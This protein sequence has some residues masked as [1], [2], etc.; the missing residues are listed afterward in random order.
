MA[1]DGELVVLVPVVLGG[2]QVELAVATIA[3]D[4]R[5]ETAPHRTVTKYTK[6]RQYH[7]P[8]NIPIF[9]DAGSRFYIGREKEGVWF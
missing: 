9:K 5:H 3:V 4:V 6:Q 2:V 7:C 1:D 8:W